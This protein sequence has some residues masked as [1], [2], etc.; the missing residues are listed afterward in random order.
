MSIELSDKEIQELILA[1]NRYAVSVS[2]YDWNC[3][4]KLPTDYFDVKSNVSVLVHQFDIGS[5]I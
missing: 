4:Y 2:N 3:I 5:I 1:I